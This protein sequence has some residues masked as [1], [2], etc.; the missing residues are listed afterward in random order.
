LLIDVS[1]FTQLSEVFGKKGMLGTEA[2]TN[3]MN[4]YFANFLDIIDEYDASVER[5]A[6]DAMIVLFPAD[7]ESSCACSSIRAALCADH[8]RCDLSDFPVPGTDILLGFHA[9][10]ACGKFSILDIV[11]EDGL[12]RH[13][14]GGYPILELGRVLDCAG[15]GQVA[16]SATVA[17]Y[18]QQVE[19]IQL[20]DCSHP[21]SR[22]F[23]PMSFEARSTVYCNST[24]STVS[25]RSV[26]GTPDYSTALRQSLRDRI[27]PFLLSKID[28]QQSS[29]LSEMRHVTVLFVTVKECFP[30]DINTTSPSSYSVDVDR[31]SYVVKF[32][33]AAVKEQ[34]GSIL[35]LLLDEKGFNFV[36]G[37]GFPFSHR[38]DDLRA[39]RVA[40]NIEHHVGCSIGISSG[41][42]FVGNVGQ[43]GVRQEFTCMGMAVNT[44]ARLCFVSSELGCMVDDMMHA[45]CRLLFRFEGVGTVKLKGKNEETNVYKVFLPEGP[46]WAGG[47]RG[48]TEDELSLVKRHACTDIIDECICRPTDRDT[49]TT[50]EASSSAID[51]KTLLVHGIA[52]SGKSTLVSYALSRAETLNM[53]TFSF[54]LVPAEDMGDAVFAPF[55]RI[56]WSF[57]MDFV[58]DVGG[59]IDLIWSIFSPEET[60]LLD[61]MNPMMGTSL[62]FRPTKASNMLEKDDRVRCMGRLWAKLVEWALCHRSSQ[63]LVLAFDN[64]HYLDP[65]V[66]IV[67]DYLIAHPIR[68]LVLILSFTQ[69]DSTELFSQDV[70]NSASV[71]EIC[72]PRFTEEDVIE[73]LKLQYPTAKQVSQKVSSMVFEKSCCGVPALVKGILTVLQQHE[74]LVVFQ[75]ELGFDIVR[76][77]VPTLMDELLPTSANRDASAFITLLI[78][79][80]PPHTQFLARIITVVSKYC[81]EFTSSLLEALF[82][83]YAPDESCGSHIL[84]LLSQGIVK[85]RLLQIAP[86]LQPTEILTF[87][88]VEA[89]RDV[90]QT[91]LPS[92]QFVIHMKTATVLMAAGAHFIN[93]TA[94]SDLSNAIVHLSKVQWLEQLLLHAYSWLLSVSTQVQTDVTSQSFIG[95]SASDPLQN[96]EKSF[97]QYFDLAWLLHSLYTPD[98]AARK[99]ENMKRLFDVQEAAMASGLFDPAGTL[100]SGMIRCVA[101]LVAA[102]LK[103]SMG[104]Y[105]ESERFVRRG[106]ELGE[107]EPENVWYPCLICV[108]HLQC[109]PRNDIEGLVHYCD[110]FEKAAAFHVGNI[111]V[112]AQ[113]YHLKLKTKFSLR[114]YEGVEEDAKCLMS[115]YHS[116]PLAVVRSEYYYGSHEPVNCGMLSAAKAM[117]LKG[118]LSKAVD[119]TKD[120]MLPNIAEKGPRAILTYHFK[121]LYIP[122]LE[123]N[124]AAILERAS[125]IEELVAALTTAPFIGMILMAESY[126]A[127]ARVM[128]ATDKVERLKHLNC[129]QSK[130]AAFVRIGK[131]NDVLRSCTVEALLS[132]NDLEFA[133]EAFVYV[134]DILRAWQLE[135]EINICIEDAWLQASNA[136]LATGSSVQLGDNTYSAEQCLQEALR[137]SRES[138]NRVSELKAL[139]FACK[140]TTHESG[141]GETNKGCMMQRAQLEECLS[142]FQA[143]NREEDLMGCAP[144]S[145][146]LQVF[147]RCPQRSGLQTHG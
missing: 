32:I 59:W 54:E 113:L 28:A 60:P 89:Q 146:A 2:F 83:E 130:M 67:V 31:L 56:T 8:I 80:L 102:G 34:E 69:D 30:L 141:D 65:R 29:F 44:A 16:V 144:I 87:T 134:Q 117:W 72:V 64:A 10:I 114:S 37:F 70:R 63:P 111:V 86:S 138:G 85:S 126:V 41:R 38:R 33:T 46:E 132:V 108:A 50:G 106:L 40:L 57:F 118:Y 25:P 115:Y 76:S 9:A 110:L 11:D 121:L 49:H 26:E 125:I 75:N 79:R 143:N 82:R 51:G 95:K 81:R 84:T 105:K 73:Y 5:F 12:V 71:R 62:R 94:P 27:H 88:S 55:N 123:R 14:V 104:S 135:G 100:R 147:N 21:F 58:D 131:P 128:T 92:M 35:N 119:A 78:D 91:I 101:E 133:R 93:G 23:L 127:F 77:N 15:R 4:S 136:C 45:N 22:L 17:E 47:F 1:G 145:A 98:D 137:L 139:L 19:H 24:S 39:L 36:I 122:M 18:L 112:Q 3:V 120:S 107:M 74:L 116:D 6:G 13:I 66:K 109:L 53:T 140:V 68:N 97:M 52:G 20:A 42:V 142:W 96:H 129:L 103:S 48:N 124:Y 43:E 61:C 99:C 7:N 90:Y